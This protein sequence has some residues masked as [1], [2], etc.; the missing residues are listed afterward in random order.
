MIL[1]YSRFVKIAIL[2]LTIITSWNNRIFSIRTSFIWNAETSLVN[3]YSLIFFVWVKLNR[4]SNIFRLQ[5]LLINVI[6][7]LSKITIIYHLASIIEYFSLNG[8]QL[9][10]MNHHLLSNLLVH[11]QHQNVSI[12]SDT[13][14][15][16]MHILNTVL[17]QL[18][19]I[20]FIVFN[21]MTFYNFWGQLNSRY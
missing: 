15:A 10:H 2:F 16:V 19:Q 21:R 6:K 3:Y 11:L 20:V 18:F 5:S 14:I 7:S 4:S 13:S 12:L 17:D 9:W 1:I 8:F